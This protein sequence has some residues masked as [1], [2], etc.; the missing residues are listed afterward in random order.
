[1]FT[2][3]LPPTEQP[4]NGHSE[5]D[6]NA[7]YGRY[8]RGEDADRRL[9][10]KTAHKALDIPFDDMGIQATTNT[11]IGWKEILALGTL[12]A[13]GIAAAQFFQK[14]DVPDKPDPPPV[15]QPAD[16][17]KYDLGFWDQ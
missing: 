7:M 9:Y 14:D 5:I 15:V 13:G 4:T 17:T 8:Q 11:G 12:G 1:M 16:D 3:K 2:K 6:K 10:L